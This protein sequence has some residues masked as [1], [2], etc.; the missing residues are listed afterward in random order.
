M[1]DLRHVS[2]TLAIGAGADVKLVQ[3]MLGHKDANETLNTYAHLWPSKVGEV[4]SLV[5]VRRQKAVLA[6]A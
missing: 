3:H 4:I 2:A 1:H 6:A 5:E